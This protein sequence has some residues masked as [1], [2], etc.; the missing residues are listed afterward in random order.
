M[1]DRVRTSV[2][3]VLNRYLDINNHRRTPERY[4]I[5]D[6]VY[7]MKGLF[8]LD[9]LGDKL[10]SET[11]FPVSRA[12]LY[13]TL[14]LFIELRLV[15]RHKFLK[16]TMYE[17][18]YENNNVCHQVCTVCGKVSEINIPAMTRVIDEARLKR[19]HKDGYTLYVYGICSSCS[20]SITRKINTEKKLKNRIKKN[21]K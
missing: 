14:K 20:A 3:E 19:F 16:K 13:N 18:C 1:N 17:A 9:T 4:A 7:G 8:S 2:R 15:V 10:M 6:A 12:T 5:L 21:E 11:K